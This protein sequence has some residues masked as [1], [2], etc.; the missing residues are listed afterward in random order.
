MGLA[1]DAFT[2]IFR[3]S[4]TLAAGCPLKISFKGVEIVDVHFVIYSVVRLSQVLN[5][6]RLV[7]LVDLSD[8]VLRTVHASAFLQK[9]PMRANGRLIGPTLG[10]VP[11]LIYNY[12]EKNGDTFVRQVVM[13]C[14]I[15]AQHASGVLRSLF[16]KG[17]LARAP[18]IAESGGVE[19][20]YS[21]GSK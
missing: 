2:K 13:E 1:Q 19:F 21:M 12:V 20:V 4:R 15:S 8:A 18:M 10:D 7:H 16:K 9:L 14:D 3:H 6:E 11:S 17:L 5:G